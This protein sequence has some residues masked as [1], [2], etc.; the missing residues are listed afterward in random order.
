[1]QPTAAFGGGVFALA[2]AFAEPGADEWGLGVQIV[3]TDGFVVADTVL[4][5]IPDSGSS[6]PRT[7]LWIGDRFLVAYAR[8]NEVDGTA[9][10]LIEVGVDGEILGPARPLGTPGLGNLRLSAISHAEGGFVAWW[11]SFAQQGSSMSASLHAV[12]GERLAGPVRLQ[13]RRRWAFQAVAT[14]GEQLAVFATPEGEEAGIRALSG[15]LFCD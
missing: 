11:S 1:M 7:V 9:N 5:A 10:E 6:A 14:R 3:D 2:Y 15:P 12:S 8:S 4:L 13:P